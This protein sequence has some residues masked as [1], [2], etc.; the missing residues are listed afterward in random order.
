VHYSGEILYGLERGEGG[1]GVERGACMS[2]VQ[3]EIEP[4]VHSD[5][6]QIR[7]LRALDLLDGRR[8]G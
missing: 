2:T 3:P 1:G 6:D 8:Q 5:F 7:G 4:M